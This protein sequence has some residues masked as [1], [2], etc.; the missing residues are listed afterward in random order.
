MKKQYI[1]L[2]AICKEIPLKDGFNLN[3]VVGETYL[4]AQMGT[5]FILYKEG[6]KSNIRFGYKQFN[7][8]FNKI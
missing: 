1:S 7:K 5:V 4:F 8:C 6:R 3:F 2:H